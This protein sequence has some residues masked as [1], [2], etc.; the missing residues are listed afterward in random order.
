LEALSGEDGGAVAIVGEAGV[1]KSTLIGAVAARAGGDGCVVRQAQG[2]AAEVDLPFVGLHDL[3]ADDL[4]A[5]GIRM[6]P[7][8]R[9]ALA[10]TML[11]SG[12]G[13]PSETDP[14]ALHLGVVELLELLSASERMLLVLDDL[15]WIDEPTVAALRFALR[16]VPRSRVSVAAAVRPGTVELGELLPHEVSTVTLGGLDTAGLSAVV[17]QQTGAK[18]SG[19]VANELHE[20]SGGNPML[21]LEIVRRSDPSGGD[22]RELTVPER[23]RAVLEERIVKLSAPAREALLAAALLSRPTVIE[24]TR[25]TLVPGLEEAEG[26]ELVEVDGNRIR[27]SH[28]LFAS[29]CRGM[30]SPRERRE[31]HR[32]L[33]SVAA[34]ETERARHLGRSMLGPDEETAAFVAKVAASAAERAATATAADLALLAAELTPADSPDTHLSRYCTAAELMGASGDLVG[35]A[36]LLRTVLADLDPGPGR[37]RC[38]LTMATVLGGDLDESLGWLREARNQPGLDPETTLE[39][40]IHIALNHFNRTDFVTVRELGAPLEAPAEA[41]GRGDLAMMSR[42]LVAMAELMLGV[43]SSPT[44]SRLVADAPSSPLIY[45]HPDY[46]VGEAALLRDDHERAEQLI[47]DLAERARSAGDLRLHADFSAHLAWIDLRRGR[48]AAARATL[49]EC[50]RVVADGRHDEAPLS[51]LARV[52]ALQGDVEGSR[53]LAQEALGMAQ[54]SADRVWEIACWW[55][56]GLADVSVGR[57]AE[58]LGHL[59]RVDALMPRESWRHPNVAPWYADGV[60]ARLALSRLDD[61]VALTERAEADAARMGIPTVRAMAAQCRGLVLAHTGDLAGAEIVLTEA[62]EIYDAFTLPV[63]AGRALLACGAVR[64]RMRQKAQSR[65]DLARARDIFRECGAAVWEARA[66]RELERAGAAATGAAL[67]SSERSVAGLAAA[68]VPNK[69]IAGRLYLS[70]KTVEAVLTRVYRK[71]SVRSRTELARHPD[72]EHSDAGE[73]VH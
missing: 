31:M 38:L 59:D 16:R 17:A 2:A 9:E 54:Q 51:L 14:V 61:A 26:A 20:L 8:M 46:L 40:E 37:A 10:A 6:T 57:Y 66:E 36:Q 42:F 7:A 63:E 71:L 29:T 39:I 32:R 4:D 48:L 24:L 15:Q 12:S 67:T 72:L 22:L 33:A 11:R 5:L 30:V 69:E 49:E 70:E 27:F 45:T 56:L 23:H 55:G 58:A 64:R 28:P 68:G 47:G 43:T 1:G 34:D 65:T 73:V 13:G 25:L 18:L 62:H 52:V 50:L 19:R 3:F 21:A 35:P 60:E 44:W 41:A 53:A